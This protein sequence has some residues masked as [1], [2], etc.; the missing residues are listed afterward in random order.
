[1]ERVADA[2]VRAVRS[3]TVNRFNGGMMMTKS[4]FITRVCIT[5]STAVALLLGV[6]AFAEDISGAP[7]E[8]SLA[9][10]KSRLNLTAEQEQKLRPI[11]SE[12]AD[13]TRAIMSKYHTT[14]SAEQRQAKYDELA[15]ARHDFRARL[16]G[17]LTPDQ[18]MEWDKMRAEA[19]TRAQKE[20][21]SGE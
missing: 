15:S 17:V 16:S 20:R 12:N 19:L 13:R 18:L 11:M 7:I 5:G 2:F 21:L 9:A 10:A 1:M 6:P 3:L 8:E 14:P 4:H